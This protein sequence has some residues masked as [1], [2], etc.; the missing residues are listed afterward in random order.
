LLISA[1]LAKIGEE[2][3]IL[4]MRKVEE[5]KFTYYMLKINAEGGVV[6]VPNADYS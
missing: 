5:E 3:Y 6:V 4:Q 2:E 1:F